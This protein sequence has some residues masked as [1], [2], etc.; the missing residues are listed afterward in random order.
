M[1]AA[2]D[3]S[4]MSTLRRDPSVGGLFSAIVTY[5]AAA[6]P[7]LVSVTVLFVIKTASVELANSKVKQ[8]IFINFIFNCFI[9]ILQ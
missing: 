2:F 5:L 7:F 1:I 6:D 3:F 9:L 8:R 4:F